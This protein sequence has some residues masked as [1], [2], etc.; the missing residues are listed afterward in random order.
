M[1]R[2]QASCSIWPHGQTEKEKENTEEKQCQ[3]TTCVVWLNHPPITACPAL[4][5]LYFSYHKPTHCTQTGAGLHVAFL[6]EDNEISTN[7]SG[8]ID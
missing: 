8:V 5:L 2:E 4:T 3:Y 7:F 1:E 6:G